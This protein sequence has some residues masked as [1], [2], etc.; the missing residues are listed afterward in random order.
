MRKGDKVSNNWNI[1]N[2]MDWRDRNL[3]TNKI[4]AGV[5]G[6]GQKSVR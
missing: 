1:E 4:E 2:V 3:V 6:N 5:G